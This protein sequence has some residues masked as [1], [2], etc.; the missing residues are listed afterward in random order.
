VYLEKLLEGRFSSVSRAS[1]TGTEAV[2]ARAPQLASNYSELPLPTA[3]LRKKEKNKRNVILAT[4]PLI[5]LT[6]RIAIPLQ[7]G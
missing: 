1:P 6:A 5:L 7:E 2:L 3:P 4:D